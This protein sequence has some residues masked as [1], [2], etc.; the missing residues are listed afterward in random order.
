MPKV[1]LQLSPTWSGETVEKDGCVGSK[2]M[3]WYIIFSDH[4]DVVFKAG[5]L[6]R[7][8]TVHSIVINDSIE[9]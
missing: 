1:V 3:L 7:V 2:L 8:V 5:E 6:A 4:Y 9:E